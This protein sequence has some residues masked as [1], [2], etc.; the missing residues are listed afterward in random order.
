M[1]DS[2]D[3]SQPA[4]CMETV[5]YLGEQMPVVRIADDG[6]YLGCTIAGEQGDYSRMLR[7]D[8]QDLG[9]TV[10]HSAGGRFPRSFVS[11]PY[12]CCFN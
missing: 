10:S 5:A 8:G 9:G 3:L 6:V 1:H 11:L 12:V 2:L 4:E 7:F